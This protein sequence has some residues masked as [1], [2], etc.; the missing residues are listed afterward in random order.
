MRCVASK[1]SIPVGVRPRLYALPSR[2]YNVHTVHVCLL[3]VAHRYWCS[4]EFW[5]LAGGTRHEFDLDSRTSGLQSPEETLSAPPAEFGRKIKKNAPF[6][7][8][9]I[10][11]TMQYKKLGYC[12]ETVRR[13]SMPRIAEMDVE[14]TT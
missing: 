3:D 1:T 5:T 12:W 13:E 2:P 11:Y 14:M 7:I 8:L 4:Q 9:Y 10:W 6:P